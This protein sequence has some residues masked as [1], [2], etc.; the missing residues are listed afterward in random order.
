MIS[1]SFYF[2][3]LPSLLQYILLKLIGVCSHDHDEIA[4]WTHA[5]HVDK[6]RR[7]RRAREICVVSKVSTM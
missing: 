1:S 3:S 5:Q 6:L 4:Q 2:L 7:A